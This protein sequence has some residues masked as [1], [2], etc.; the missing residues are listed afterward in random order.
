MIHRFVIGTAVYGV[1]EPI[2]FD[3]LKI[4]LTRGKYH[5]MSAEVSVGKLE[6]YDDGIY[7]AATILR[8]AYNENIDTEIIYRVLYRITDYDYGELWSGVVDLSTYSEVRGNSTKVSVSVGEIGVK[9]TFNNRTET[10]VDLN[11]TTTMNGSAIAHAPSFK[12]MLVPRKSIAYMNQNATV[13]NMVWTAQTTQTGRFNLGHNK[14]HQ[15]INI[16]PSNVASL[17]EF[18]DFGGLTDIASDIKGSDEY[19][20]NAYID[21]YYQPFFSKGADWDEKYGALA[22]YSLDIDMEVTVEALGTL[23][24]D[25]VTV[26]LKDGYRYT[27]WFAIIGA[28]TQF[29][30]EPGD[31]NPIIAT[32]GFYLSDDERSV[33]RHITISR[34]NLSYQ[35]LYLGIYMYNGNYNGVLKAYYWSG[36]TP[37]RVTIGAGGSI[38]MQLNSRGVSGDVRAD[39]M[40]VHDALNHVAEC[41]TDNQLSVKSDYYGRPDSPVYATSSIGAGALKALT[42]GYKIRGLYSDSETERNMPMSFKNLIEG[43]DAIDCVGWGIVKENN[44]L[45]V[46]VENWKWFYK[47]DYLMD[48][49][50]NEKTLTATPDTMITSLTI[51]Y[52]KYATSEDV[53]SIDSVHTERVF[54]SGIKSVAKEESKL[55]PF[56]ADNYMIE[57]TRRKAIEAVSDEFKYDE[58]IFIFELC[59]SRTTPVQYSIPSNRV[60]GWRHL[61]FGGELYNA[62]ISPRRNAERWR[63]RIS[64][65]NTTE[66]FRLTKGTVNYK[67]GFSLK[68]STSSIIYLDADT[69]GIVYENSAINNATPLMKA[70]TLKIECPISFNYFNRIRNNP[71]GIIMVDGV[72]HWLKELQYEFKRGM[73]EMTLI[74]KTII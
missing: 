66:P 61:Q 65:F 57:E 22:E 60:R 25:H 12:N 70:E 6:F 52:K 28:G 49:S 36:A 3:S 38:R 58:N 17:K 29:G 9:T 48:V 18:G 2:G 44:Q 41:I 64:I 62:A 56:I 67:A 43:L 10:E 51:G 21:E 68:A 73:A 26:S 40:L 63:E 71:Y 47:N 27:C 54:T 46:R 42:N 53:N 8:N 39:M 37:M 16:V 4:K 74:P 59:A 33:T 7:N 30:R 45:V 23:F 31:F 24:P 20:G 15:W 69:E 19:I 13:D 1:A 14:S 32:S 5:G 34:T 72:P 11:G 50:P 35:K 55:C